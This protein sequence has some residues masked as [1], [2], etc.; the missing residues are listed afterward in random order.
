M[1]SGA[2]TPRQTTTSWNGIR[3]DAARDVS[4]FFTS[5]R[6]VRGAS[7]RCLRPG[8]FAEAPG[9]VRSCARHVVAERRALDDARI[10][11]R[12]WRR[13]I[14]DMETLR[15]GR[16]SAATARRRWLATWEKADRD[17]RLYRAA[18]QHVDHAGSC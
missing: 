3:V 17:L 1:A 18:V 10:S 9:P 2:I 13:H 4:T 5:L 11:M 15:A 7:E 8:T 12:T 16:I 6:R 14:D